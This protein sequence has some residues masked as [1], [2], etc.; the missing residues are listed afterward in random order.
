[1]D[2]D[3]LT[4][5][6]RAILMDET[7]VRELIDEIQ[8]LRDQQRDNRPLHD[9]DEHIADAEH[10][11]ERATESVRR[12]VNRIDTLE[13]VGVQQARD[14]AAEAIRALE[15]AAERLDAARD[16]LGSLNV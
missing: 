14:H 8:A 2:N 7:Q 11:V 13:G 5:W 9:T 3:L 6:T 10:N 12:A 1:M 4:L 16:R 15:S